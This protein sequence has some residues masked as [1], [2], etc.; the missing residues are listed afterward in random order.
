MVLYSVMW[1][2]GLTSFLTKAEFFL[3]D[4]SSFL[5]ILLSGPLP[6]ISSISIIIHTGADTGWVPALLYIRTGSFQVLLPELS[7]LSGSGHGLLPHLL[8]LLLDKTR[9]GLFNCSNL[10]IRTHPFLFRLLSVTLHLI[11][12]TKS[13]LPTCGRQ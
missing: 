4:P 11:L 10:S 2:C 3:T 5:S 7:L 13:Y 1:G 9:R 8:R 6:W 12:R